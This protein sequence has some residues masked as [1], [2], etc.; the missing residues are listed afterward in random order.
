MHVNIAKIKAH[1]QLGDQDKDLKDF[2]S[3]KV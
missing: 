3:F 1:I 2:S